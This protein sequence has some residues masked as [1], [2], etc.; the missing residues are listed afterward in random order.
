VAAGIF[1][2]QEQAGG[3]CDQEQPE[4]DRNED[5]PQLAAAVASV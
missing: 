3:R 2:E 1:C 4:K 5:L